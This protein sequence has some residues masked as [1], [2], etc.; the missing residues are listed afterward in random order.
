MLSERYKIDTI[1]IRDAIRYLFFKKMITSEMLVVMQRTLDNGT[2]SKYTIC[3]R[4]AYFEHG[5]GD[6]EPPKTYCH[7][8][9]G[10]KSS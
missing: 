8:R 6:E 10:C 9:N 1:V 3:R 5:D 4:F 7:S 2:P